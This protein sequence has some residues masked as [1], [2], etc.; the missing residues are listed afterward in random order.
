ML[1][2]GILKQMC[3]SAKQKGQGAIICLGAGRERCHIKS[4]ATSYGHV[5]DFPLVISY[6][7]VIVSST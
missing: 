5:S 1:K 7:A 4:S 2:G 6:M 3:F